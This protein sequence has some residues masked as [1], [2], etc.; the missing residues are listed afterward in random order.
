AKPKT[1]FQQLPQQCKL[2]VLKSA[3]ATLLVD[4]AFKP[5]SLNQIVRLNSEFL[6]FDWI[7]YLR[8][9]LGRN[10][11][12]HFSVLGAKVYFVFRS[13][14]SSPQLRQHTVQYL[15]GHSLSTRA[16]HLLRDHQLFGE[17]IRQSSQSATTLPPVEAT[18]D[19]G[20]FAKSQIQIT[21]N[22]GQS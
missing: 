2:Q 13:T 12:Q 22:M 21:I 15:I 10:W 8:S 19:E 9:I 7:A 14:F 4:P 20:A 11:I 5:L 3:L 17:Y 16:T 6:R 1:T 18:K